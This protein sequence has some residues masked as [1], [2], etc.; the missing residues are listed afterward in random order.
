MSDTIPLLLD[1]DI[2]SDIDDAVALAYLLRQPR[3][4]LL[5]ITT[6]TGDVAKRAACA[7]VICRAAGRTDVPIHAGAS[8]VL[9][10]GPG[11]AEVPQYAA[12]AALP[13]RTDFPANT[14]VQ[15]LRETIRRRPGEITL[16]SIG[17]LTN[18]ALLFALDGEIP[19][20]LKQYV[21]MGGAYF[22]HGNR[23]WN[24]IA[25]PL[26]AAMAYKARP[27]RH[28]CVGLDVTT[29]CTMP[30]A[31]VRRRFAT[32]PL[33]AVA[34]MA[35]VWFARRDTITFH[36]PLAAATVFRPDLCTWVQ[37]LVRVAIDADENKCGNTL[38]Q[39]GA[40]PHQVARQVDGQAF[41]EEYFGVVGQSEPPA[42]HPRE[43][44]ATGGDA[45][46][47]AACP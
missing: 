34:K 21:M 17:P 36:D 3:C 22:G 45:A 26:A 24:C 27:P 28:R 13:H 18:I 16:L 35:E 30:A 1:T 43:W 44:P 42:T 33:D 14:A 2:G 39:P 12:V 11:Q 38:F 46:A 10:M 8:E 23:E 9:L 29:Q 19:R 15:F 6:V 5:G 20:L 4:E 40:G 41:F 7:Q 32:P 31:E 37:G 25:D 47:R